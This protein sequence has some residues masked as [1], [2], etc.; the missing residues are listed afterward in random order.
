M[1]INEAMSNFTRYYNLTLVIC[2]QCYLVVRL[3]SFTI[4][5]LKCKI[6]IIFYWIY[7]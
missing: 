5:Y 3:Q 2:I 1:I 7:K 6:T 4:A